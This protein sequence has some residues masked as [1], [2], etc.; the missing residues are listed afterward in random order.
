MENLLEY[1]KETKK[2]INKVIEIEN[3][4]NNIDYC[5]EKKNNQDGGGKKLKKYIKKINEINNKK[6]KYLQI[7]DDYKNK[8]NML[9][10]QNQI[11]NQELQKCIMINFS[12]MTEKNNLIEKLEFFN[13]TLDIV[14]NNVLTNVNQ[15]NNALNQIANQSQNNKDLKN[16]INIEIDDK[17]IETLNNTNNDTMNIETNAENNKVKTEIQLKKEN[18]TEQNGGNIELYGGAKIDLGELSKKLTEKITLMN[19]LAKQTRLITGKIF[20]TIGDKTNNK[21]FYNIRLKFEWLIKKFKELKDRNDDIDNITDELINIEGFLNE[22]IGILS[23][24]NEHIEKIHKDTSHFSGEI[25]DLHENTLVHPEKNDPTIIQQELQQQNGIVQKGGSG[26]NKSIN[27]QL[28]GVQYLHLHSN[29]DDDNY[30]QKQ[31]NWLNTS[32][33]LKFY[34]DLANWDLVSLHRFHRIK[35][36]YYMILRTNRNIFKT[37]QEFDTFQDY[38]NIVRRIEY[39]NNFHGFNP[40]ETFYADYIAL[41]NNNEKINELYEDVEKNIIFDIHNYLL[42]VLI[43][44]ASSVAN[45]TQLEEIEQKL[46]NINDNISELYYNHNYI[47]YIHKS[48]SEIKYLNEEKKIKLLAYK[49]E[50]K[51]LTANYSIYLRPDLYIAKKG[52]IFGNIFHES[53]DDVIDMFLKNKDIFENG[54]IIEKLNKYKTNYENYIIGV[55]YKSSFAHPHA[56]FF[57]FNII[58]NII[59]NKELTKD[60]INK[61]FDF[62]NYLRYCIFGS[63]IENKKFNK[64]INFLYDTKIDLGF[65]IENSV[66]RNLYNIAVKKNSNENDKKFENLQIGGS[67]SGSS[68]DYSTIET[69]IYDNI[70]NKMTG[71]DITLNGMITIETAS[72]V[73]TPPYDTNN[74]DINYN[75]IKNIITSLALQI[76]NIGKLNK[77]ERVNNNEKNNILSQLNNDTLNNND[78]VDILLEIKINL[79]YLNNSKT[80]FGLPKD[81]NNN[82]INIFHTENPSSVFATDEEKLKTFLYDVTNI[83]NIKKE[84]NKLILKINNLK[85]EIENLNN[86]IKYN[87][88]DIRTERDETKKKD[89][90]QS[91]EVKEKEKKDKKDEL[92]ITKDEYKKYVQKGGTGEYGLQKCSYTIYKIN[93]NLE[94]IDTYIKQKKTYEDNKLILT[95]LCNTNIG[96]HL[97]ICM[98]LILQKN[99]PTIKELVVSIDSTVNIQEQF[100]KILKELQ[101]IIKDIDNYK[102][103]TDSVIDKNYEKLKNIF[104]SIKNISSGSTS[105]FDPLKDEIIALEDNKLDDINKEFKSIYFHYNKETENE[106]IKQSQK[107][108]KL[109]YEKINEVIENTFTSQVRNTRVKIESYITNIAKSNDK[110]EKIYNFIT[111]RGYFDKISEKYY[112]KEQDI[113]NYFMDTSSLSDYTAFQAYEAKNFNTGTKYDELKERI[114][115]FNTIEKIEEEKKILEKITSNLNLETSKKLLEI[116]NKCLGDIIEG[117]KGERDN[118]TKDLEYLLEININLEKIIKKLYDEKEGAET[119]DLKI[120]ETLL[121]VSINKYNINIKNT[122]EFKKEIIELEEIINFYN[123]LFT[124]INN[125]IEMFKIKIINRYIEINICTYI[126]NIDPGKQESEKITIATKINNNLDDSFT[127]AK[128]DLLLNYDNTKEQ[129]NLYMSNIDRIIST[130]INGIKV[131]VKARTEGN[132]SDRMKKNNNNNC[133]VV[134]NRDKTASK[135]YG[136]FENIYWTDR[137]I[138]DLYCGENVDCTKKIP[139]TNSVRDVINMGTNANIF[140]TYGFSGSGKTTLLTGLAHESN[141]KNKFGI[142]TRIIKDLFSNV[143]TGENITVEYLIGEVY[144][145]KKNLS[146]LD[147]SFY[148]CLYL[149]DLKDDKYID[150]IY[151]SDITEEYIETEVSHKETDMKVEKCKYDAFKQKMNQYE[152]IKQIDNK[153]FKLDEFDYL[154]HWRNE[155]PN[156]NVFFIENKKDVMKK[157]ITLKNFQDTD[158]DNYKTYFNLLKNT[159]NTTD[160]NEKKTL[161]ELL[162]DDKNYEKKIISTK[163]KKDIE[164]GGKEL[165]ID[166]DKHLSNIEKIRIK[167]NRIRCTKFNPESSRSHLF[168]LV[169][170]R[171]P[172]DKHY[173]Y[174]IFI[175]KAGSEIPFEIASDEFTKLA[176]TPL[177]IEKLFTINF[178]DN[179]NIANQGDDEKNNKKLKELL[180]EKIN[181]DGNKVFSIEKIIDNNNTTIVEKD[182]NK[183]SI[184]LYFDNINNIKI[185]LKI[186]QLIANTVLPDTDVDILDKE[187]EAKLMAFYTDVFSSNDYSIDRIKGIIDSDYSNIKSLFDTIYSM[188]NDTT[189]YKKKGNALVNLLRDITPVRSDDAIAK[190]QNV[191]KLLNIGKSIDDSINIKEIDFSLSYIYNETTYKTNTINYKYELTNNSTDITIQDFFNLKNISDDELIKIKKNILDNIKKCTLKKK[192]SNILFQSDDDTSSPI[193]NAI[194]ELKS[195]IK[196]FLD[197]LSTDSKLDDVLPASFTFTPDTLNIFQYLKINGDKLDKN[198]IA[199]LPSPLIIPAYPPTTPP[200]NLLNRAI[201][202]I[203]GSTS[204]NSIYIKDNMMNFSDEILHNN[205]RICKSGMFTCSFYSIDEIKKNSEKIIDYNTK[206]VFITEIKL[207]PD[208]EKRIYNIYNILKEC[209]N[210]I[211]NS[212]P[213]LTNHFNTKLPEI[214]LKDIVILNNKKNE[215]FNIHIDDSIK[216]NYKM[217]FKNLNVKGVNFFKNLINSYIEY[218]NIKKTAEDVNTKIINEIKNNIHNIIISNPYDVASPPDPDADKKKSKEIYTQVKQFKNDTIRKIY[219]NLGDYSF[220]SIINTQV[221]LNSMD[222]DY[223]KL[224]S[225]YYIQ[226]AY[227][228]NLKKDST[229]KC[230]STKIIEMLDILADNVKFLFCDQENQITK[231]LINDNKV[232]LPDSDLT[233]PNKD[234]HKIEFKKYNQKIEFNDIKELNKLADIFNTELNIKI[235]NEIDIN[236]IIFNNKFFTIKYNNLSLYICFNTSDPEINEEIAKYNILTT[237]EYREIMFKNYEKYIIRL[238][239]ISKLSP[240]FGFLNL[241]LEQHDVH[242]DNNKWINIFSTTSKSFIN[243]FNE[244]LEKDFD[245]ITYANEFE[246]QFNLKILHKLNKDSGSEDIMKLYQTEMDKFISSYDTVWRTVAD[247][248]IPIYLFNVRQGFWINH[249]IRQLMRT[250]M[251]SCEEKWIDKECFDFNKGNK[252]F[253]FPGTG[254]PQS[255]EQYEKYLERQYENVYNQ[256][257]GSIGSLEL[258]ET[259]IKLTNNIMKLTLPNL[260]RQFFDIDKNK[261]LDKLTYTDISGISQEQITEAIFTNKIT[262]EEMYLDDYDIRNSPWLKLLVTIQ[263]LGADILPTN[264]QAA[265]AQQP[266]IEQLNL[267]YETDIDKLL[268]L[269][270][271]TNEMEKLTIKK[272]FNQPIQISRSITLLLALSTR[273]DKIDGVEKTLLFADIITQITNSKCPEISRDVDP[274][275]V[276]KKYKKY[277]I[278]KLH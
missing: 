202:A 168:F 160:G 133:V 40:T 244:L 222:L 255:S 236:N 261:P 167:K 217:I 223:S 242:I 30:I 275:D 13:K 79:E 112:N 154:K 95:N 108:I 227:I 88:L 155:V 243:F 80:I 17:F 98:F 93:K 41:N 43:K 135:N 139:L 89:I 189:I 87:K 97:L 9:L 35:Q 124:Y 29:L 21:S 23:N 126:K 1:I 31:N 247:K 52:K 76:I 165:S 213:I 32:K 205:N 15:S 265:T 65:K 218:V 253:I 234:Y 262:L 208:L 144:G 224:L 239:Y 132:D 241:N 18:K 94:I 180:I 27:I 232:L 85:G 151:I 121:N 191:Y 278:K 64:L 184:T 216:E 264:V 34:K 107:D 251:Y 110:Y 12:N 220:N 169:R 50:L 113:I 70:I 44:N 6:K 123:E 100:K 177:N 210:I 137:T 116:Y 250:L 22:N 248:L 105:D 175:D 153:D 138:A 263:H 157:M 245:K 194:N 42:Y 186:D 117:K 71:Q 203:V 142:I 47:D 172:S 54:K 163:T 60:K 143:T 72:S 249:S 75:N 204:T 257:K 78:L 195:N 69:N 266:T 174:N 219:N 37:F 206:N 181:K 270:N 190:F 201:G 225:S 192:M 273:K 170:T 230:N 53:Y 188:S 59:H 91:I 62:L 178:P 99:K 237:D 2:M 45:T 114:E 7:I 128:Q 272:T 197:L 148:E 84:S 147:N 209:N 74:T 122:D 252:H 267:N 10:T 131:F 233:P 146:L 161:L 111:P 149:W 176:N 33:W 166:L 182:N 221:S 73:F 269:K 193:D 198:T 258:D 158:K 125:L 183:D 228:S 156:N 268:N 4:M 104:T 256:Q 207:E 8:I 48:F 83:E 127:K 67:S 271:I 57:N 185:T 187:K 61:I 115:K 254:T 276:K 171:L 274:Q 119:D 120:K 96:N 66:L 199:Q 102:E 211:Y 136:K 49:E 235:K 24:A 39:L 259:K 5:K 14:T 240:C 162:I 150:N 212:N 145:E 214:S 260:Q 63:E 130:G 20:N 58:E 55:H 152:K 3:L 11:V 26:D 231:Q 129:L 134:Y 16:T 38:I 229:L 173:K 36:F 200:K 28:G 82:K 246:K 109:F 92:K 159:P 215:Q 179:F 140:F 164:N 277:K 118:K 77:I 68:F 226:R 51:N 25:D 106:N 238:Y 86:A 81:N 141:E 103:Y 196:N 56:S 46:N 90:L 19:T 101:D